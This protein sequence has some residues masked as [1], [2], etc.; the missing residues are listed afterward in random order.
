LEEKIPKCREN[1]SKNQKFL[2]GRRRA[3][4][5]HFKIPLLS[6]KFHWWEFPQY[7]TVRRYGSFPLLQHQH[8]VSHYKPKRSLSQ[9]PVTMARLSKFCCTCGLR[10]LLVCF[11]K[12]NLDNRNPVMSAAALTMPDDFSQLGTAEFKCGYQTHK[13]NDSSLVDASTF[14]KR[15]MSLFG[16]SPFVCA[17]IW[18]MLAP[19]INTTFGHCVHPR[20]LLW[21]L[22]FLKVYATE[23]PMRIICGGGSKQDAPDEKTY[24]KWVWIFVYSMH[25]LYDTLVSASLHCSFVSLHSLISGAL[26][27][28]VSWCF[29]GYSK[30]CY[31]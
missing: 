13:W 4:I 9:S 5:K 10:V 8:R 20:H 11:H 24:R 26:G 14:Q 18:N 6:P 16:V 29:A 27:R 31:C 23:K 15:W 7:D 22:C 12:Y 1:N 2:P 25:D 3:L 28:S 19:T 21:A 30:L 17:L